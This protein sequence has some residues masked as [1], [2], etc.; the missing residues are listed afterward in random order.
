MPKISIIT[1]NLNNKAGLQKTIESVVGQ[2]FTDK[3]YIIIDGGSNDGSLDVIKEY[4]AK[5][6]YWISKPDGGIFDAMNKGIDLACGEWIIFMNSADKF[7]DNRT[8]DLI[9]NTNKYE[10]IDVIYGNT[11]YKDTDK[12]LIAP[13]EIKKRYFFNSTLCHQS[14][15]TNRMSFK[16]AGNYKLEYKYLSDREWLLHAKILKLN[17]QFLNETISEW[18]PEGFCKNNPEAVSSEVNMM[19]KSHFSIFEIIVLH[20]VK[21]ASGLIRKLF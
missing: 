10:N 18:D 16:K 14:I 17:F 12:V 20:L 4:A 19:R 9:F 6:T 5:I 8:L 13:G 2:T 1:V 15:F 21:K 7:H 11:L 3:E